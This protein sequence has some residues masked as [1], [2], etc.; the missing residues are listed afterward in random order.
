M[1]IAKQQNIIKR[2]QATKYQYRVVKCLEEGWLVTKPEP[3]S[4]NPHALTLEQQQWYDW[5]CMTNHLGQ[6]IAFP[7]LVRYVFK[8]TNLVK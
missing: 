4:R 6:D 7:D 3:D 1:S 8:A 5:A 2:E